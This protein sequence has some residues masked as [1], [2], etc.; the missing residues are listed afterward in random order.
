MDRDGGGE[1]SC[2]ITA[3][4]ELPDATRENSLSD[5]TT[6]DFAKILIKN[7]S[8]TSIMRNKQLMAWKIKN[9]HK[10]LIELNILF[11]IFNL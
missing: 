4:E 3:S 11:E 9:L 6:I 10:K 8:E 7:E 5:I 1:V 2:F